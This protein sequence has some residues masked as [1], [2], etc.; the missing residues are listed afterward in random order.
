MKL[1]FNSTEV[2]ERLAQVAAE[3]GYSVF[4][5]GTDDDNLTIMAYA[6]K[7][8]TCSQ[9]NLARLLSDVIDHYHVMDFP[10]FL[11]TFKE[12]VEPDDLDSFSFTYPI[13][14]DVIVHVFHTKNILTK[15]ISMKL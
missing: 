14:R 2:T 10:D 12:E 8:T 3:N 1:P 11:D 7:E 4:I 6:F 13:R 5:N 9:E 15:Q